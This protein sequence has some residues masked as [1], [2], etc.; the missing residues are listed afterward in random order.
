MSA[1]SDAETRAWTRFEANWMGS[2]RVVDLPD[3]SISPALRG[4]LSEFFFHSLDHPSQPTPP[5]WADDDAILWLSEVSRRCDNTTGLILY[6]SGKVVMFGWNHLARST[7]FQTI[8]D[9]LDKAILQEVFVGFEQGKVD[10]EFQIKHQ[11]RRAN[12]ALSGSGAFEHVLI[13]KPNPNAFVGIPAT[14]WAKLREVRDK[15]KAQ[16]RGPNDPE[17]VERCRKNPPR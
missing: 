17:R 14:A 2:H 11:S 15:M 4:L 6:R 16:L 13:Y 10:P 3:K 1:V 8:S 9:R 7:E 5:F 12:S